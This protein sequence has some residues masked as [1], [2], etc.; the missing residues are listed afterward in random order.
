MTK[1][2]AIK[3]LEELIDYKHD[4]LEIMSEGTFK[5]DVGDIKKQIIN[6]H[7]REKKILESILLQLKSSKADIKEEKKSAK[8]DVLSLEMKRLIA[9]EVKRGI[10]KYKKE[11]M[12][13]L[14]SM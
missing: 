4:C 10:A 2:K 7:E 9:E 14:K 6:L 1:S 12:K 13:L 11:Q 8:E 5:T 3:I